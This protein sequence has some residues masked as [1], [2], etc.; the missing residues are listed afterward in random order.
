M[1]EHLGSGQCN[2]GA[3][4]EKLKM[5]IGNNYRQRNGNKDYHLN[6]KSPGYKKEF[7]CMSFLFR[8]LELRACPL[9]KWQ[10]YTQAKRLLFE[11]LN[12]ALWARLSC[13]K[14]DRIFKT[15]ERRTDHMRAEH[16]GTFCFMY[17]EHF[18]SKGCLSDHISQLR[19]AGVRVEP[20]CCSECE[21]PKRFK[22]EK[23]FYDHSWSEHHCC[24]VCSW[25]F[26][27]KEDLLEHDNG[28]H[29]SA[30]CVVNSATAMRILNR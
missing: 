22:S 18:Y 20:Y 25:V 27:N 4:R 30:M 23:E 12:K 28:D 7:H 3:N 5:H 16:E 1:F 9:R 21:I 19:P 8:H 26:D 2:S 10:D 15:I 6:F 13:T 11:P 17:D 14:C 29:F 24:E